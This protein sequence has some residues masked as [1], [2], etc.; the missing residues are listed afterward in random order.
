[1]ATNYNP[2]AFGTNPTLP[3]FAPNAGYNA[4]P[5]PQGG[6]GLFGAVPGAVQMPNPFSDLSKVYP[7]LAASNTA[8]S[9]DVMSNLSGILSPDVLNQIQTAGAQ[10]AFSQGLSGSGFAGNELL[11]AVGQAS[12]QEQ[13]TG[14]GQYNTVIPQIT[15]SQTVA[16]STEAEIA[17]SNA[18]S[19]A[20]PNPT[21]SGLANIFGD[22]AGFGS[23][24]GFGGLSGLFGGG[25]TSGGAFGTA[26]V[27]SPDNWSSDILNTST[28]DANTDMSSF[29]FSVD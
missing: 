16:P 28:I 7:N 23:G 4:N 20:A 18:I 5:S 26:G 3:S 8:A 12:Q 19:A 2:N 22:L 21:L 24:G 27:V 9:G 25:G 13:S 11:D 14:E 10:N 6:S 17:E 15:Q 1:M 29:D